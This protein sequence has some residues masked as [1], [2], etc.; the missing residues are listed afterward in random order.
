MGAAVSAFWRA[1]NN[2]IAEFVTSVIDI[3]LFLVI[4][5]ALALVGKLVG[6]IILATV[7][8]VQSRAGDRSPILPAHAYPDAKLPN[9]AKAR[10]Q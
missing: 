8:A 1:V 3:I 5:F 4:I 9:R 2:A 7:R 10:I 6:I